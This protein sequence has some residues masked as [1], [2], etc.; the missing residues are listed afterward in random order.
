[1]PPYPSSRPLFRRSLTVLLPFHGLTTDV[2]AASNPGQ[3]GKGSPAKHAFLKQYEKFATAAQRAGLQQPRRF[4][5]QEGI[6][7]SRCRP[8]A[9]PNHHRPLRR[10][11]G[12]VAQRPRR[13]PAA[14]PPRP[15]NHHRRARGAVCLLAWTQPAAHC[16]SFPIGPPAAPPR[17][18]VL[19]DKYSNRRPV[20]QIN[21]RR[22]RGHRMPFPVSAMPSPAAA[23]ST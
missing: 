16:A 2:T 5:S 1:M 13:L 9:V 20:V 18:D 4:P 8:R 17:S 14:A 11:P 21:P 12:A 7:P 6:G 23:T 10:F 3:A 22:L 19:A 15:S